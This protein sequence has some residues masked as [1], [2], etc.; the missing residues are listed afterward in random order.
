MA[1]VITEGVVVGQEIVSQVQDRGG[2]FT[3]IQYLNLLNL[4]ARSRPSME[5]RL[6]FSASDRLRQCLK[7]RG[8]IRQCMPWAC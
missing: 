5:A 4:L 8:T 3:E 2:K 7:G 6:F 1:L